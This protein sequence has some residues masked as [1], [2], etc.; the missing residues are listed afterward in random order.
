MCYRFE[1]PIE[2]RDKS[3]KERREYFHIKVKRLK[4]DPPTYQRPYYEM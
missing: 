3:Q 2:E 4:I 1:K